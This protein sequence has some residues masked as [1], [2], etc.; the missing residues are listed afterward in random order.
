MKGRW[1]TFSRGWAKL[2]FTALLLV[3]CSR[4]P[5]LA[6]Y[7]ERPAV[8]SHLVHSEKAALA[9]TDCHQ[10]AES[11]AEAGMPNP[12]AC[13]TCHSTKEDF[14]AK[15]KPF[16]VEGKVR[17]TDTTDLIEDVSF[18]HQ[19]HATA[20]VGCPECHRGIQSSE[21]VSENLAVAKEACLQCH[22]SKGNVDTCK[23]CHT[24]YDKDWRPPGHEVGWTRA[25][26]EAARAGR[27]PPYTNDCAMC[28]QESSCVK[29]HM[30]EQPV[31]HTNQWRL[32]GHGITAAM[33][34]DS[35]ATCHRVDFCSSCHMESAPRSHSAAWGSPQD[36]HC[37]SCHLD[38][39]GKEQ[40][41]A[42]CHTGAASHDEAAP[43]PD[44]HG[45]G[46]DCRSCHGA[47]APLPHPDNG[48]RCEA[49]HM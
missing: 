34:R 24:T 28:H 4:T 44:Y 23:S 5:E 48:D 30:E 3:G 45:V 8:F 35:C 9:C 18:D 11:A 32:R 31:N 43:V 6:I 19:V 33:D 29:C 27:V 7:D 37:M 12:R 41:C 21:K 47:G 14:E 10:G 46:Q 39:A 16:L 13:T 38:D 17:W 22:A 15:L 25:H 49:C 2:G 1:I 26:G 20:Q 36:H 40:G 42:T